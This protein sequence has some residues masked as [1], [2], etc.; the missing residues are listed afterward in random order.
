MANYHCDTP[1]C[2]ALQIEEVERINL[3][4]LREISFV[5]FCG[6]LLFKN[7]TTRMVNI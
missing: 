4:C 5:K 2:L 3:I 7:A 1:S 6:N